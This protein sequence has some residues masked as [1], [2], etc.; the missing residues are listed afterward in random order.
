MKKFGLLSIILSLGI[1][2]AYANSQ[3][4]ALLKLAALPSSV[5]AG[6]ELY[7]QVCAACHAKDLS[8]ATGFNL[9]D[10]EWIHGESP[11]QILANVKQGFNKAGMP[12]FGPMF[13]DKQLKDVVAY[14]VSERE[15]LADLSFKI[16][17]M[18]DEKDR[19][20]TEDKLIKSGKLP[21]NLMDF[22]MP[23]IKH[24]TLE[25][26]GTLYAPKE[27]SKL[28]IEAWK[29]NPTSL[30]IDGQK[31][32]KENPNGA[33]WK[34]KPGKQHI[35]FQYI[36]GSDI[37]KNWKRN[38]AL[39]VATDDLGVKL[40]GISTRSNKIMNDTKVLVKADTKPVVQRKKIH[41][42]PTYSISVGFPEKI[43]YAF[44]TRSCDVVGLWKGDLLNVGPNVES[45][46]KDGSLV[47][48]DWL[49]NIKDTL[50]MQTASKCRYQKMTNNG[51]PV[52]F[53][54]QNGVDYQLSTSSM[55]ANGLV[56]NYQVLSKPAESLIF[57]L[58]NNGNVNISSEDGVIKGN[59][60]SIKP[61]QMSFSISLSAK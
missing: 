23:E 19:V 35:K 18:Q 61:N 8:G 15:G 44:N 60:L 27:P 9:K 14:I 20:V 36:V 55:S 53:F 24:Y 3:D 39:F 26:E 58:P 6:Q 7:Q 56:L 31:V 22:E 4:K 16:Y 12:A 38:L 1:S 28:H 29:L 42:L 47:L 49:I 2:N 43:N 51:V 41:N 33:T 10:G 11:S 48:G 59:T 45:R 25:F 5:K 50:A 40:F 13:S 30:H 54:N 52:F 32:I 34:I 37:Q 21:K 57:D 17:Q 46:G